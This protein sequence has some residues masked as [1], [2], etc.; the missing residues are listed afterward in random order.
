MSRVRQPIRRIRS[1]APTRICDIGGWTDTWFAGYGSVL[2]IAVSPCVD[3]Q[4]DVYGNDGGDARFTLHARN[5][6]DR[7]TIAQPDGSYDR[8]PLLEAALDCMRPPEDV[9]LEL[10]IASDA[11]AGCS[12]G[13]SASVTVAVIGA[14]A[15]LTFARLSPYEA[16]AT[17]Q[18]I[19]TEFLR[20]QC[21]I[22]DQLAA[23]FG[24]INFIAMDRYPHATVH[25][26]QLTAATQRELEGRLALVYVGQGHSSSEVHEMVIRQLEDAGAE[27]P[28]LRRLRAI[29]ARA[30]VVLQA[31][32][33]AGFGRAMIENTEAQADL[34]PQLAGAAHQQIIG[35]ARECGALGWKVN[36]AGGEGGSVTLLCG[37]DR[38]AR[39]SMLRAIESAN[40]KFRVIP[41]RLSPSGLRVW[42]QSNRVA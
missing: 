41:I 42:E 26:M 12:T 29:A 8:H 2:N 25:R 30:R 39:E 11:P 16:A 20:R 17:A 21:G 9:A 31:G 19:E 14:L 36:G 38:A 23:A 37:P 10:T 13:T 4:L 5:F 27:A 6:D 40:P 18:R 24:G 15:A 1:S 22:Q 34:H 33:L 35:I 28:Q 32:D 3:V 7:Y